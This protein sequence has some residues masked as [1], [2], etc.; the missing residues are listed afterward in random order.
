ME[1]LLSTVASTS[2][3]STEVT[4]PR[5]QE[6]GR[7]KKKWREGNF[8]MKSQSMKHT[9]HS[10]T[11]HPLRLSHESKGAVGR[12]GNVVPNWTSCVRIKFKIFCYEPGDWISRMTSSLHQ[13]SSVAQSCP[14]LCDPMD[15]S[16]PGFPVH[17][18]LPQLT[19]T[20]LQSPWSLPKDCAF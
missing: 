3:P 19:Q 8:L 18:Q 5:Q 1:S 14:T 2:W 15:C 10:S 11:P 7:G 20:H 6:D 4:F 13:F 12:M 17:H 9:D 16:T